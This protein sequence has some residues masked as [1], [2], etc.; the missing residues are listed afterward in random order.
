MNFRLWVLNWKWQNPK[1][2]KKEEPWN[3]LLKCRFTQCVNNNIPCEVFVMRLKKECEKKNW[4]N[5]SKQHRVLIYIG[6]RCAECW[7]GFCSRLEE[8]IFWPSDWNC[9]IKIFWLIKKKWEFHGR[10]YK[11][12]W[13]TAKSSMKKLKII[14][15]M[16]KQ[17]VNIL[18]N[19]WSLHWII[20][21]KIFN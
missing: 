9:W 3:S 19:G 6:G 4:R 8:L 20:Q 10:G 7:W 17:E 16:N 2:E 14:Q 1:K 18:W 15:K 13:S 21:K 5:Y 12:L 11:N